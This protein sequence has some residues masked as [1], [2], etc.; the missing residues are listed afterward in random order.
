MSDKSDY[1]IDED[2]ETAT[3]QMMSTATSR[4]AADD[5]QINLG[6]STG[7]NDS[8]IENGGSSNLNTTTDDEEGRN[9]DDVDEG[10]T[11]GHHIVSM[12]VSG[13]QGEQ[14]RR[15][16]HVDVDLT[17]PDKL[18]KLANERATKLALRNKVEEAV[19]ERVKVL[20]LTR[21]VFG[22]GHWRVPEAYV[23]LAKDYL[24]LR[25]LAE[26]AKQ[27]CETAKTMITQI[28]QQ[29][30][31]QRDNLLIVK[32]NLFLIL[33]RSLTK[34]KKFEEAESALNR[35]DR[36]SRERNNSSIVDPSAML[37]TDHS[38]ATALGRLYFAQRNAD[39]AV[40]CFEQ[41]LELSAKMY[42]DDSDL[43]IPVLTELG[44]AHQIGLS[45]DQQAQKNSPS[46]SRQNYTTG[47]EN[48]SCSHEKAIE[49]FL[50]A[51][52]IASANHPGSSSETAKTAEVVA[53]GYLTIATSPKQSGTTG[54]STNQT[55]DSQTA[56]DALRSAETYFTESADIF[57]QL[58]GVNHADTIRVTEQLAKINV[59]L[60]NFEAASKFAK[61]VLESKIEVFG[62]TS[63][64][65]AASQQTLGTI[66][67]S[68]GNFEEAH[69]HLKKAQTTFILLLGPT[70]KRVKDIE[71]MVV[72]IEQS[73]QMRDKL[74]KEKQLQN[75]PAFNN[76][77]KVK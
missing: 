34:L 48:N 13:V 72:I 49:H 25:G 70:A 68:Q 10:G 77:F 3:S 53:Q 54:R 57:L 59:K 5:S 35:A 74:S 6:H 51:H 17:P 28:S 41:V 71:K 63:E 21:I 8:G 69:K 27:H 40:T 22:D 76:I 39:K 55:S 18:L 47:T 75:R 14:G 65:T 42:G 44:K 19:A 29:N 33:G 45:V 30:P 24:E 9:S 66:C 20:A 23:S 56:E 12:R 38:I 60:K 32:L 73:P 64:E 43:L 2:E 46:H 61:S 26:Q 16:Q 52:S 4:S 31:S 67:L 1:S 7:N 15:G 62:D 36:C 50:H 58:K 11:R 37:K